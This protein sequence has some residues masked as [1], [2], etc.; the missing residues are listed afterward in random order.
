MELHASN[1]AKVLINHEDSTV[2]MANLCNGRAFRLSLGV[3]SNGYPIVCFYKGREYLHRLIMTPAPGELVDHIN[4]NKLDCRRSNLRI[5]TNAQ[6]LWNRG[7]T[8]HNT[9]GYKGVT[10]CSDTGR[11]RAE[12]RVNRKRIH[13]GRF[14]HP[15]EAAKAYDDAARKHHGRYCRTNFASSTGISQSG[16][17]CD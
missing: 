9:S 14:D 3:A 12:I 4:G 1:G 15:E 11:W 5:V 13:L 7:I 2:V 8:A 16:R 17:R 10:Y 6:N